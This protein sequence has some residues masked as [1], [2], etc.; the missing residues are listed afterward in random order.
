MH[1]SHELIVHTRRR[2]AVLSEDIDDDRARYTPGSEA[3][4]DRDDVERNSREPISITHICAT[5]R[6]AMDTCREQ[7]LT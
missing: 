2:V 6:T 5:F 1:H 4:E 3:S 7:I